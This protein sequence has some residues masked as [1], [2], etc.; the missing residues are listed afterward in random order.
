MTCKGC[1]CTDER[2]CIDGE[3]GDTCTWV[4]PELCSFCYEQAADNFPELAESL[5]EPEPSPL[6]FDA[7]G[8]PAVWR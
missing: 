4:G 2:A 8:A 6:L 3:T 1:G 5:A 7:F